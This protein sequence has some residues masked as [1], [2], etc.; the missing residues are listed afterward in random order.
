MIDDI[1]MMLRFI[2]DPETRKTIRILASIPS[3]NKLDWRR[4]VR[5]A[6]ARFSGIEPFKVMNFANALINDM[7]AL[8]V[9]E[10]DIKRFK[11]VFDELIRN[12]FEHGCHAVKKCRVSINCTYSRWFIAL[13]VSDSGEGFDFSE[14]LAFQG[15]NTHG[16]QLVDKLAFKLT[17]NKKGNSLTALL[18]SEPVLRIL[19]RIEECCG[20]EILVLRVVD[21]QDWNYM[22]ADWEPLR[23]AVKRA[24]QNL[25]L[26]DCSD[27]TWITK[28][29]R[30]M[31]HMI[32]EFKTS[33][34]RFFALI[35]DH[36][37]EDTFDFS[38]LNSSN[39]KVFIIG[40]SFSYQ[41]K[42]A[43]YDNQ[44]EG[45]WAAKEW[46]SDQLQQQNNQ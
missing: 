43:H 6:S 26:I 22:I 35:V 9:S 38:R 15:D 34:D 19:P 18:I 20:K 44:D 14:A 27:I 42:L 41:D 3:R 28:V 1:L 16:L 40:S 8:N 36:E 37:A 11:T 5:R 39:F 30:T 23:N 33:R 29:G 10:N 21:E 24:S 45:L 32:G 25:V 7:K 2:T 4:D 12:A 46:L 13:E 31:K 17:A